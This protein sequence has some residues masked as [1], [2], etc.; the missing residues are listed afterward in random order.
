M[1]GNSTTE[2][3][4]AKRKPLG[5]P[6]RFRIICKADSIE[7]KIEEMASYSLSVEE[8]AS[9]LEM[10]RDAIYKSPLYST[11]LK[12][13]QQNC[14]ASLRRRQYLEAM[15]GNVTMLIWLG[16]QRL[17]QKDKVEMGGP[18]GKPIPVTL[19]A[20]QSAL[21]EFFNHL[22]ERQKEQPSERVQ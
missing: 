13:G 6:R 3:S 22:R 18:D 9:L 5:R 19:E 16:K 11:A 10:T 17:Q 8:I 4:T 21:G 1:G 7:G 12:K 15:N 14:N 20:A 2:E